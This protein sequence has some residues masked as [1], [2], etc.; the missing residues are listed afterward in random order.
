[1]FYRRGSALLS[2]NKKVIFSAPANGF[3]RSSSA[4]YAY[5][6]PSPEPHGTL[7]PYS[8]IVYRA[9]KRFHLQRV[10]IWT[11]GTI[12]AKRLQWQVE[13]ISACSSW[14]SWP[15]IVS[16][17][18]SDVGTPYPKTFHYELGL[19]EATDRISICYFL[20]IVQTR[21]PR[22]ERPVG[23]VWNIPFGSGFVKTWSWRILL[24][25][26]SFIQTTRNFNVDDVYWTPVFKMC[27]LL[28]WWRKNFLQL[29]FDIYFQYAKNVLSFVC[30]RHSF[31]LTHLYF[32]NLNF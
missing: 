26:P 21:L 6:P 20:G 2:P 31:I 7:L 5:V 12:K 10:V 32:I 19:E 17:G 11:T 25:Y 30:P 8:L 1:M 4:Q 18:K 15:G 28:R 29:I 3:H 24:Q 14:R 22:K 13:I 16:F 9:Q 27:P 23:T